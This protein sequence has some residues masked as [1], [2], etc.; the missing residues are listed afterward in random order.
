MSENTTIQ[1]NLDITKG[2]GAILRGFVISRGFFSHILPL[3]G[4]RKSFVVARTSLCRGSLYMLYWGSTGWT[5]W[6]W[7][8][9]EIKEQVETLYKGCTVYLKGDISQLGI[10][11]SLNLTQY[12]S[13]LINLFLFCCE[14]TWK[15]SFI[16]WV[17]KINLC[18]TRHSS[19]SV[20]LLAR[21]C[22]TV[23]ELGTRLRSVTRKPA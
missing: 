13:L 10:F 16:N 18:R 2:Q 15:F 23:K 6:H 22:L 19:A 21:R 7:N 12:H 1:W 17:D 9:R 14:Y 4:Q 11:G 5:Q 8:E 3:L 20:C